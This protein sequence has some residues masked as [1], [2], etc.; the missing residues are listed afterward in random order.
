M[1]ERVVTVE[2][3]TNSLGQIEVWVKAVRKALSSLDPKTEI[4]LESGKE[5]EKW[6][7]ES[8]ILTGKSC[9]PPD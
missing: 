4:T 8:A 9:P 7:R 6:A 1:K 5:A 2:H 3:L